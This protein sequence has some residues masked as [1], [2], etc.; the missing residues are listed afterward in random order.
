[1]YE[2][3]NK[4][5]IHGGAEGK[6]R[7]NILSE[8]LHP[9]MAPYFRAHRVTEG[10]T[11][12]DVGCGGGNVSVLASEMVGPD[13]SVVG[14]DFDEELIKLNRQDLA[15]NGISNILY[16]ASDVYS[17][18]YDDQFDF[19][20]ARFLLSHL[21]TPLTALKKLTQSEYFKQ[22]IR[23]ALSAGLKVVLGLPQ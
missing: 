20:F 3:D 9:Y 12:L 1:M 7:L 2:Q 21:P 11:F 23:D 14:I 22:P 5:I 6:A 10:M 19:V 15:R 13:G 4:Y 17:L 8:T 16:E 18:N